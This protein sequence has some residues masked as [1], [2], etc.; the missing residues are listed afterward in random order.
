MLMLHGGFGGRHEGLQRK[1]RE[2]VRDWKKLA[3]LL[4]LASTCLAVSGR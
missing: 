3:M 2:E 4:K 1:K